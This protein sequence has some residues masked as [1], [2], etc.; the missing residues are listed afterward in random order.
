MESAENKPENDML[1]EVGSYTRTRQQQL[2]V[3]L[4]AGDEEEAVLLC[5]LNTKLLLLSTCPS[6]EAPMSTRGEGPGP[7]EC[8]WIFIL[9]E[10][11]VITDSSVSG[12]PHR[13]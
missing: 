2:D 10:E 3:G 13:R 1:L 5:L 11:I 7:G 9:K 6:T 4:L 12:R 8:K